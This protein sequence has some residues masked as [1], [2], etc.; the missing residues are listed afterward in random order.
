MSCNCTR[1]SCPYFIIDRDILNIVFLIYCNDDN[2]VVCVKTWCVWLK[3]QGHYLGHIRFSSV[4]NIFLVN[5]LT[6]TLIFS[7]PIFFKLV[8][9]ITFCAIYMQ[10]LKIPLFGGVKTTKTTTFHMNFLS[11]TVYLTNFMS[12]QNNNMFVSRSHPNHRHFCDQ[13][14]FFFYS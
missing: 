3:G 10:A 8:K 1:L 13:I 7:C 12:G 2:C 11:E 4:V 6:V 9:N 5:M 14:F